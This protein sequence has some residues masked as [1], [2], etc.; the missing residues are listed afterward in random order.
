MPDF[1]YVGLDTAGREEVRR[2]LGS[3]HEG[4]VEGR[5]LERKSTRLNSRH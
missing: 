5:R 2:V 1:A 3:V 4:D